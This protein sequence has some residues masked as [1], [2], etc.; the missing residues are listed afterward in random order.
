M[1]YF[2]S[3]AINIFAYME[4]YSFL[5]LDSLYQ[6]SNQS[7]AFNQNNVVPQGMHACPICHK[8]F[9]YKGNMKEH[10]KKL[11]LARVHWPARDSGASSLDSTSSISSSSIRSRSSVAADSTTAAVTAVAARSSVLCSVRSLTNLL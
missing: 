9:K 1:N 11:E 2:V 7:W 8:L 10:L 4:M 3:L 6:Q 5:G